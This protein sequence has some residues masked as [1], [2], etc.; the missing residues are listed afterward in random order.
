MCS[1][2]RC[3]CG[4]SKK[5]ADHYQTEYVVSFLMGLNG[6]FAQVKGQ[7]LLM[8]PI[9][10]IN[11]VFS[12]VSQ[13]EH[14]RNIGAISNATIGA[15][16]MAFYAR[17]DIKKVNNGQL[18]NKLQRKERPMRT[19]SGYSGHSV[20]KCYK[21][22]CYPPGYKTKQKPTSGTQFGANKP[23]NYVAA[24]QVSESISK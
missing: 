5:L 13:E 10:P 1:C 8:D 4:G 6:S 24:N 14:Q 9:P 20:D 23:P 19:H 21:L 11:K 12:L 3:N 7:I 17:S 16:S 22:H 2:G 18:H 15:D